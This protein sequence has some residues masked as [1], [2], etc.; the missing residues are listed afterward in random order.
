MG[1]LQV[2]NVGATVQ[3][4]RKLTLTHPSDPTVITSP[5][6]SII[7]LMGPLWHDLLVPRQSSTLIR[8]P[9]QS[10]M[11]PHSDPEST[12]QICGKKKC[13]SKQVSVC[14]YASNSRWKLFLRL[15]LMII[16]FLNGKIK[17]YR[18]EDLLPQ[19]QLLITFWCISF[20]DYYQFYI[21]VI[22]LYVVDNCSC[23]YTIDFLVHLL[24]QKTG[25]EL[26]ESLLFKCNT[27]KF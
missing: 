27:V 17:K 24:G 7:W 16:K 13:A 25:V 11:L 1:D 20:Q 9:S 5:S 6:S 14:I 18:N 26:D 2:L 3:V 19:T 10:S 23:M 22:R 12:W 15:F 8:P 4:S 21:F